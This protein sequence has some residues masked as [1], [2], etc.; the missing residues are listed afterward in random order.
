MNIAMNPVFGDQL[1]VEVRSMKK[2]KLESC[3]EKL[4]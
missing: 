1:N 2:S 4:N 3:V